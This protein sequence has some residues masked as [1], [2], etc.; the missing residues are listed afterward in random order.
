MAGERAAATPAR[1]MLPTDDG[2]LDGTGDAPPIA[3]L[4]FAPPPTAGATARIEG[5]GAAAARR[6]DEGAAAR[7]EP[8]PGAT[9]ARNSASS[10]GTPPNG[11]ARLPPMNAC[12][13]CRCMAA[14]ESAPPTRGAP[15]SADACPGNAACSRFTG[16][17]IGPACI[18][19]V[20][21]SGAE[22]GPPPMNALDGNRA[23]S[24]SGAVNPGGAPLPNSASAIVRG[25]RL[26]RFSRGSVRLLAIV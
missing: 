18:G 1:N 10:T 19:F 23:N 25:A 14:N 12:A 3:A 13:I 17:A 21:S 8:A 7:I 22:N 11:A 5:A 16:D 9:A 2:E 15:L 4:R 26:G 24:E 20:K 6:V